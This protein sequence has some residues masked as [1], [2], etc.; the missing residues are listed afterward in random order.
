M[1]AASPHLKDCTDKDGFYTE[2]AKIL[3]VLTHLFEMSTVYLSKESSL[4]WFMF[5]QFLNFMDYKCYTRGGVWRFI[6][7][8]INFAAHEK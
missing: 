6:I 7:L 3:F 8:S 5:L 1:R 2:L 4:P